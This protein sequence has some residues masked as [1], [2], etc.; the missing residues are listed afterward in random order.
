MISGAVFAALASLCWGA[1]T[2]MSKSALSQ[3]APLTLLVVQLAV[4]VLCLWIVIWWRRLPQASPVEL[5]RVAWLGL[6]EPGL[7]YMLGL[8]GL[9]QVGAAQATLIQSAEGIMIVLV[10]AV[11]FRQRPSIR[12]LI[13]SL[14]ALA[15]LMVALDL[16]VSMLSLRHGVS[17]EVLIALATLVAAVYVV[18]SGAIAGTADAIVI[19]A[20]QQSVAFV[21]A[22]FML[23]ARR[24][25]DPAMSA[26]PTGLWP[27]LIAGGSGAV[28]YAL[29]FTLYMMALRRIPANTAGAF[30][31]LTPVFGLVGATLFLHETLSA[32][33]AMG[34][35]ATLYFVWRISRE[36]MMTSG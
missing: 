31:T 29:A 35:A 11:V 2:V 30:L 32:T 6:L 28:Q 26:L 15:G 22:L 18:L 33:Q 27:W 12:F 23:A 25:V 3:F 17:A 20:W 9:A 16:S 36:A 1:A 8:F 14:L 34:A 5:L 7:A 4:S 24:I 10:S 19:V 13:L 21:F